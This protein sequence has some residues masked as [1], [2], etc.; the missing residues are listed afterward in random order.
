[1]ARSYT[2]SGAAF[3]TVTVGENVTAGQIAVVQADNLGY[4]ALDPA[5]T[6]N[7]AL[8]PL[9]QPT[10]VNAASMLTN[11]VLTGTPGG[12]A[13][14]QR[15]ASVTLPNGNIVIAWVNS[16]SNVLF[17][18]Y[19]PAGVLQGSI[20]TAG[21]SNNYN[22]PGLGV[23]AF[24]NSSFV[25]VWNNSTLVQYAIFTSAGATT[26]AATTALTAANLG[27][28]TPS[29]NAVAVLTSGN[30]VVAGQATSGGNSQT[31]IGPT[32]TVVLA[33]STLNAPNGNGA[34]TCYDGISVCALTGGG[35]VIGWVSF[36]GSAAYYGNWGRYNNAGALQGSITAPFGG[37]SGPVAC[38][39]L[40]VAL[41]GGGFAYVYNGYV[42][43][44]YA[45]TYNASGTSQGSPT[46]MTGPT[47]L[48]AIALSD[49]GYAVIGL[50]NPPRV[51]KISATGVSAG[52]ITLPVI[53]G[54]V[55][56]NSPLG[57]AQAPDT[58]VCFFYRD[59]NGATI[60]YRMDSALSAASGA[61]T[62]S[63]H[64]SDNTA[65]VSRLNPIPSSVGAKTGALTYLIP[66]PTATT[67]N[68]VSFVDR[69]QKCVPLGVYTT[70]TTSGQVA[71][72]QCLGSAAINTPFLQPFTA[73]AQ[74]N[75]PPGQRMSVIGSSATMFG[76]ANSIPPAANAIN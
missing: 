46:T 37:T 12:A 54:T 74:S 20:T 57:I 49:G 16:S 25:L 11:Q 21:T 39:I 28:S 23:A 14:S 44:L 36:D 29:C 73:S 42:G 15:I 8:R 9:F 7:S 17:G 70:T 43:T 47:N 68:L 72:F 2:P 34:S 59:V 3:T 76:V 64:I 52:V 41:T 24:T 35:Y 13:L 61:G 63:T 45:I 66:I 75:N 26:V 33:A 53:G 32:G 56:N 27:S 40:M 48:N 60:L 6:G 51:A 22:T 30:F 38:G 19:S 71:T 55:N 31:I 10:L 69:I 18:I 1:M 5:V 58:T 62:L 4:Y 67:F 65:L 50:F